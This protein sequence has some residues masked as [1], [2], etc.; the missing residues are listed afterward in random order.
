M[1]KASRSSLASAFVAPMVQLLLGHAAVVRLAQWPI[2][3]WTR[4]DWNAWNVEK[5]MRK[6]LPSFRLNPC[7]CIQRQI[8]RYFPTAFILFPFTA[9][10]EEEHQPTEKGQQN[11]QIVQD[12]AVHTLGLCVEEAKVGNAPADHDLMGAGY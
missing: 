6:V 1:P 11:A 5:K 9:V 8:W 3:L 2:H 12:W 10:H 7:G 4:R